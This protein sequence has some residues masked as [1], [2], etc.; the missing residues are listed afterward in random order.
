M[1]SSKAGHA[2]RPPIWRHTTPVRD[3]ATNKVWINGPPDDGGTLIGY[4]AH[5]TPRAK[6]WPKRD[7]K[8]HTTVETTGP[9]ARARWRSW[10]DTSAKAEAP[11]LGAWAARTAA[12]ERRQV[13]SAR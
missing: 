3:G 1:T 4:V 12:A 2:R 13:I 9:L 10:F 8:W 5:R 6:R 7:E 11:L